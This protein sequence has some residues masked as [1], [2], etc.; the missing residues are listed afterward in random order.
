MSLRRAAEL[1]A[2]KDSAVNT[3]VATALRGHYERDQKSIAAYHV[4]NKIGAGLGVAG[5][6]AGL[7]TLIVAITK[8]RAAR[9]NLGSLFTVSELTTKTKEQLLADLAKNVAH[10]VIT[11]DEARKYARDVTTLFS[12]R[13]NRWIG[14][15][16]AAGIT[17]ITL[18][19]G[20][21]RHRFTPQ[22]KMFTDLEKGW[23]ASFSLPEG[24]ME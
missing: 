11:Q 21:L 1:A 17:V 16:S 2:L 22:E 20:M 8:I 10:G 14:L 3:D 5:A 6:V 9:K 7:A 4:H 19:A 12:A 23:D 13:R 15:G 18:L 24:M